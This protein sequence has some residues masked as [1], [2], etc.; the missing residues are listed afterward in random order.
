MVIELQE[1][2]DETRLAA[3]PFQTITAV[4]W[5]LGSG[6][7]LWCGRRT[8]TSDSLIWPSCTTTPGDEQLSAQPAASTHPLPGTSVRSSRMCIS[9][10]ARASPL[11][12][13]VCSLPTRKVQWRTTI[14]HQELNSPAPDSAVRWS[15]DGRYSS[16]A[17]STASST[18]RPRRQARMG[19]RRPSFPLH[20][21]R[22]RA[23][24]LFPHHSLPLSRALP[25]RS[26]RLNGSGTSSRGGGI[27][28]IASGGATP[29]KM[30]RPSHSLLGATH[31]RLRS[32]LL[33][34]RTCPRV[35][36]CG[37]RHMG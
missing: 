14:A 6:L 12:R 20:M 15:P 2:A 13:G 18:Y 16:R 25:C 11:V 32:D 9:S 10:R 37:T 5:G 35:Q 33:R 4:V 24:C 17:A 23:P 34:Q 29:S 26:R 21:W 27:W 30:A 3:F 8:S 22:R 31:R 36:R 1:E 7:T 28:L 19:P